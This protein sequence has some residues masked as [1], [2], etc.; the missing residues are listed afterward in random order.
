VKDG[1]AYE[2]R[3]MSDRKQLE[4]LLRLRWPDAMLIICG[5]FVRPEDVEGLGY[6]ADGRLHGIA[7]WKASGKIMHII[8]VNAFTEVRGVGVALVDAMV[9]HGRENGI[10]LLRATISNDNV[11]ALRFYQKRGFRVT[12]LHRGIYDAMRHMKPSIPA[13]GLDGIPMRDEF[14]LELEL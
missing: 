3:P 7:T 1:R 6:Y 4:E 2:I 9:A 14:E 5:Q 11:V 13:T 10:A 12:A 8:A